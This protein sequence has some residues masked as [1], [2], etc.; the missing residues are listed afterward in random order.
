MDELTKTCIEKRVQIFLREID[1]F[2]QK[3]EYK[4]RRQEHP[5]ECPCNGTGPCHDIEDLNCLFCFCPEY[6]L[7]NPEGR[8]MAGNPLGTGKLLDRTK[9]G[10]EN[11]W[12]CS[13]CVYPHQKEGIK[14]ILINKLYGNIEK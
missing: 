6:N 13:D 11:I 2:L 14:K 4:T 1:D 3:F 9:Y 7:K 8:C 10:L 12:D 5:E